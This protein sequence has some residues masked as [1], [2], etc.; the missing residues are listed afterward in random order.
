MK[1]IIFVFFILFFASAINASALLTCT[2][3]DGTSII[4]DTPKEGMKCV[5]YG[6]GNNADGKSKRSGRSDTESAQTPKFR[7][8]RI[9]TD[10]TGG[11]Y[12]DSRD[13]QRQKLREANERTR[14]RKRQRAEEGQ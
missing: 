10:E 7:D 6:D 3:S 4:T 9:K 14:E 1:N 5:V 13:W 2:D 11:I 8:S 12:I